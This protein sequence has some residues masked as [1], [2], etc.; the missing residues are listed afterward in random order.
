MNIPVPTASIRKAPTSPG[1]LR[2]LSA[3]RALLATFV[4]LLATIG[5]AALA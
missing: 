5:E 1:W 3:N 2:T 4:P